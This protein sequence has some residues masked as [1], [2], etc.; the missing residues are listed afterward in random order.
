MHQPQIP[1]CSYVIKLFLP[2]LL[3]TTALSI[4]TV[5]SVPECH[6]NVI[7]QYVAFW[8]WLLSLII[9]QLRFTS[10]VVSYLILTLIQTYLNIFLPK[11]ESH[12]FEALI[13]T[14]KS[15]K[16]SPWR[17]V[18]P[19]SLGLFL[20]WRKDCHHPQKYST[21]FGISKYGRKIS[22]IGLKGILSNIIAIAW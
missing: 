2:Q 16:P 3:E 15:E 21:D 7:K 14:A 4:S 6:I 22:P 1:S 13:L 18:P 5:S 20:L 11:K 10:V 12:A 19:S 9:I 17:I 8:A